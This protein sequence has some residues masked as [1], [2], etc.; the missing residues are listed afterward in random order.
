MRVRVTVTER[1]R[2]RGRVTCV[3]NSR[4]LVSLGLFH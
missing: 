4:N 3:A 1:V 2:V